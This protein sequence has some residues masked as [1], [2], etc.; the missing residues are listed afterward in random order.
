MERECIVGLECWLAGWSNNNSFRGGMGDLFI[1][2][3]EACRTD[4]IPPRKSAERDS[5]TAARNIYTEL[6]SPAVLARREDV[7]AAGTLI[8]RTIGSRCGLGAQNRP[9][10]RGETSPRAKSAEWGGL[11]HLGLQFSRA[12]VN[13]REE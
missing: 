11:I 4:A 6:R 12:G 8:P 7:L 1:Y 13:G 3:S 2:T 9:E 5:D 10:A